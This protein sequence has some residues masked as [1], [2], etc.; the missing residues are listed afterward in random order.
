MEKL[1]G[2]SAFLKLL[3]DEGVTNLFGNPGTTELPLMEVVPHFT[4][5]ARS[6]GVTAERV[7]DP[8]GIVPALRHALES[9]C[10][11][12]IEVMLADGFGA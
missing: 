1:S 10:P 5:L 3:I 2:R 8:E 12:L 6:L 9:G 7:T 4:G 11:R